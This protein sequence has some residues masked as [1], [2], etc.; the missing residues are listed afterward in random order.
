MPQQPDVTQ[1]PQQPDMP[2][3]PENMDFETWRSKFFEETKLPAEPF[4]MVELIKRVRD[5]TLEPYERKF[6]EDNLQV[7]YLRENANI[8]LASQ[9]IRKGIKEQLDQN[10]PS[11]SLTN[12]L[13]KTLQEM[14]E[15]VNVFIKITGMLGA[16]G[17]LHRKYIAALFGAVQV[18]SG[19]TN[20]DI[21]YNTKEYSIAI[22]T[23]F[24]S[25]YGDVFL[26][27]WALQEDDPER[28]LK[29]PE[30]N[31]LESGAPEEKEALRK[32]LVVES[33]A[34]RFKQR[35]FLVNVIQDDGTVTT[36]GM[37]LGNLLRNAYKEG[38]IIIKFS[39]S[40]NSEAM[41]EDNGG[42][43]PLMDIKINYRKPTGKLDAEGQTEY[44][45][46]SFM[47]RRDGMLML[48]ATEDLLNEA[49]GTL[50]GMAFKTLP[51]SG[52]PSDLKAIARSVPD[53]AEFLLARNP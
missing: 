26:G 49:S 22:S 36:L 43:V 46:M 13:T 35:A 8:K 50:L 39:R 42:I 7:Q 10:N 17:D 20:E 9:K 6:V 28:Y 44:E 30:L 47:E 40:E 48:M 51:Y 34:D 15:L 18:G 23:R 41:I 11:V 52:N 4:E 25:V 1:D 14:P 37:D 27:K 29:E 33:I 32:R 16:K 3:E 12:H 24:N 53:A 45:E 19:A 21:I 31:R 2:E 38:K 5:R